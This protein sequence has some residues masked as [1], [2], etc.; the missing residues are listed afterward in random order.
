MVM[1]NVKRMSGM[2]GWMARVVGG[3][4]GAVGVA[5]VAQG[6]PFGCQGF[7]SGAPGWT[8]TGS[9]ISVVGGGL[10]G[11]ALRVEDN[12]GG[13]SL[14]YSNSQ[15]NGNWASRACACRASGRLMTL[16]FDVRLLDDGLG[17]TG[18][19]APRITVVGP[20]GTATF[21]SS[22]VTVTEG[23]GWAHVVAPI[24]CNQS[25]LVSNWGTWTVSS[26]GSFTTIFSNVTGLQLPM[27]LGA[28]SEIWLFD[29]ICLK[30][31][32]SGCAAPVDGFFGPTDT[33]RQGPDVFAGARGAGI[34]ITSGGGG[35]TTRYSSLTAARA[36]GSA[37]VTQ[38]SNT[39]Y[40][41][42]FAVNEPAGTAWTV[43]VVQRRKG[44]LTAAFDGPAA[45]IM[46]LSDV[47]GTVSGPSGAPL[48]QGATL[49]AGTLA[50]PAVASCSS[51]FST[52][53]GSDLPF[54]Q[55][56]TAYISGVGPQVVTLRFR[57]QA[58]AASQ[59][60][61][62]F[63]NDGPSAGVRLG[64]STISP[65]ISVGVTTYPGEN[66]RVEADD[67]HF[68]TISCVPCVNDVGRC[69]AFNDQGTGPTSSVAL[70]GFSTV[71]PTAQPLYNT[72]NGG[73]PPGPPPGTVSG[74]LRVVEALQAGQ[75]TALAGPT[76]FLGNWACF[77]GVLEFDVRLF[78][79]GV[80]GSPNWPIR[81]ELRRQE[82]GAPSGAAYVSATWQSAAINE[83]SGWVKMRVP[84]S[85]CP[86]GPGAWDV[87]AQPSNAPA[88]AADIAWMFG[89]VTSVWFSVSGSA[90]RAIV[91]Y[92]NM[93]IKRSDNCTPA[94]SALVGWWTFD[95]TASPVIESVYN[96][97]TASAP[98]AS[99]GG[100]PLFANAPSPVP[101][102]VN[103]ALEFD[104][105]DDEVVVPGASSTQLGIGVGD[106]SIDAWVR[107]SVSTGEQPIVDRRDWGGGSA[108]VGYRMF[109]RN[110]RLALGMADASPS[111]PG[112]TVF[113][114]I[115]P[116]APNIADGKWHFVAVTVKRQ[117]PGAKVTLYVD[118]VVV[119]T[120][121]PLGKT[122]SLYNTA[123]LYIGSSRPFGEPATFFRGRIDEVEIFRKELSASEVMAIYQAC[124]AGKCRVFGSTSATNSC[125][126]I[127]NISVRLCNA[128]ST[129]QTYTLT[130][131]NGGLVPGC[132]LVTL[133]L[134]APVTVSVAPGGCQTWTFPYTVTSGT[135]GG[136]F[137]CYTVTATPVG[138]GTAFVM[139]GAV[140]G[141]TISPDPTGGGVGGGTG[142]ALMVV[143][144][145]GGVVPVTVSNEGSSARVVGLR[146]RMLRPVTEG[147]SAGVRE[148]APV[149]LNGLPPGEPLIRTLTVPGA[150]SAG[151][152][153]SPGTASLVVGLG[154][155]DGADT[156]TFDLVID[157][158]VDGDGTY[159]TLM[160]ST[161]VATSAESQPAL[162]FEG[163]EG[164]LTAECA[165]LPSLLPNSQ[166]A[167]VVGDPV[168]EGEN[169]VLLRGTEPGVNGAS[170][171]QWS[172]IDSGRWAAEAQT[173][174]PTDA[175]GNIFAL[176]IDQWPSPVHFGGWVV[177]DAS[178]NT[179]RNVVNSQQS[180]PLVR[181]QWVAVRFE[182]DLESDTVSAF[183]G[184]TPV[185]QGRSYRTGVG[186]PGSSPAGDGRII[187]L[188]MYS[189][190][191]GVDG[192]SGAY[193]DA[194]ALRY[195]GATSPSTCVADIVA[196]GGLP[197][198][199]GLLTGDD[200]NAFVAAF[201]ANDG[202]ADIVSIGGEPP[203]DGLVTGDDFVAFIAGFAAGCP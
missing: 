66:G 162:H 53:N 39:D 68:V 150:G 91:D 75:I 42:Q 108:P 59:P 62:G 197:P 201:A 56:S 124:C 70:A 52:P 35:I 184:G 41:V 185:Y 11:N 90:G 149:S 14:A 87:R 134:P 93:C 133:G 126:R 148:V 151:G 131:S 86:E 99:L 121:N 27:E 89:N 23:G 29:N 116:S 142:S 196:I 19:Y 159:E 139:G 125:F 76:A 175:V 1:A 95:R 46:C 26:G 153:L 122:G 112:E 6:Q 188:A 94:P 9:S 130:F 40:S 147:G 58:Q 123:P 154:F 158:D 190:D 127:K 8:A 164:Q 48:G 192:S 111:G 168:F 17:T 202:L 2:L 57:W 170:V 117:N 146:L 177:L 64:R 34:A 182:I 120:F 181:D 30:D 173:F 79:D 5:G 157:A 72:Y 38:T 73:A 114:S 24:P 107:T 20:G 3:V 137:A 110:G 101:G 169:A 113:Q 18:P 77:C 98:S 174:V 71:G 200:F 106:F 100:A 102:V 179:V 198:G 65:P 81:V 186:F 82:A 161:V 104:G 25:Q 138:A 63:F 84:M 172:Q 47:V 51:A 163:F 195:L 33:S 183:Y 80:S 61:G 22:M 191:A 55:T 43:K 115:G 31:C 37:T 83:G 16:E 199:D 187:G 69:F 165:A 78:D 97:P 13:P 85:G 45:A 166:C 156:G 50:L 145:T 88:S 67:G 21:T 105:V 143:P 194:M 60:I 135:I 203:P 193:V 12:P 44:E 7:E 92:D 32:D 176:V 167:V 136:G 140:T 129:T 103:G 152:V 171:V 180:V 160:S 141:C 36:T 144:L 132:A 15:W 10:P 178:N 109:L 49:T 96:A 4:L 128:G 28:G 54:D 189:G 155:G 118:G 119:G 74:H